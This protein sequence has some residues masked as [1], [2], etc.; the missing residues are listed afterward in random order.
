MKRREIK[1]CA[2]GHTAG[3]G[4]DQTISPAV[5]RLQSSHVH[6]LLLQLW[7]PCP[8]LLT[9]IPQHTLTHYPRAQGWME[10][11]PAM[12][13]PAPLAHLPLT[14]CPHSAS[15]L[16]LVRVCGACENQTKL[17]TAEQPFSV[18]CFCSGDWQRVNG[19]DTQ[20]WPWRVRRTLAWAPWQQRHDSHFTC[21]AHGE[22]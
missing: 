11:P 13:I 18:N 7:S 12:I 17:S 1:V 8:L 9:S 3:I 10:P 22:T 15:L 19:S 14:S 2:Q 6:Y 4:R 5:C 16:A 20:S 21:L